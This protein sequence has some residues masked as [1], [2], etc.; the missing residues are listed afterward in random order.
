MS[1]YIIHVS[2][3]PLCV[4]LQPVIIQRCSIFT[5]TCCILAMLL[6]HFPLGIFKLMLFSVHAVVWIF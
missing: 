1:E 2:Y 4:V 6:S 3:W 5:H